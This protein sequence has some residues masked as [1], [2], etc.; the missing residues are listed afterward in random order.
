MIPAEPAND[1]MFGPPRR[2]LSLV[3]SRVE[4]ASEERSED[5]GMPE[6]ACKAAAPAAWARK[7]PAPTHRPALVAVAATP[8]E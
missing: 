5:D 2:P 4:R 3:P 7:D 6:H 8:G 1:D